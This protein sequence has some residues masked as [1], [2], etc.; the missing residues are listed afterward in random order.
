MG[1][2]PEFEEGIV[3]VDLPKEGGVGI[4]SIEL[5]REYLR[6]LFNR[7]VDSA[8]NLNGLRFDLD[9]YW[10][11]KKMKSLLDSNQLESF[12][13]LKDYSEKLSFPL[14]GIV[15]GLV[16]SPNTNHEDLMDYSLFMKLNDEFNIPL[17]AKKVTSLDVSLLRL[18]EK[19][20]SKVKIYS[21]FGEAHLKGGKIIQGD[22]FKENI[23]EFGKRK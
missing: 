1:V 6:K 17:E 8:P 22:G 15:N 11:S 10:S 3:A 2:P 9:N 12:Q 5:E 13:H 18:S 21:S 23:Y 20:E 14:E 7:E 4:I 16:Y 19:T